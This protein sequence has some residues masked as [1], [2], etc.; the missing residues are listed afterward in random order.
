MVLFETF[1]KGGVMKRVALITGATRGIGEAV[2]KRF[3][4]EDMHVIGVGRSEKDLKT[5]DDAIKAEGG[6]ATLVQLDLSEFP[7][8]DE[9]VAMIR[10][11]FERIS[12]NLSF[13][14]VLHSR[15]CILRRANRRSRTPNEQLPYQ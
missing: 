14:L 9:M 5:L 3:A 8:I 6:S 2:A 1:E 11:R 10:E 13:L 15:E 7:K 4:R 12:S